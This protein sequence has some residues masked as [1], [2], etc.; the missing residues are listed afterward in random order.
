MAVYKKAYTFTLI[1][2]EQDEGE[3]KNIENTLTLNGQ[4]SFEKPKSEENDGYG[5]P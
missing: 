3:R 5:F 4:D 1:D 2:Q